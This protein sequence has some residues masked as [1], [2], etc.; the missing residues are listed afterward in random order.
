MPMPQTSSK[1]LIVVS[2]EGIAPTSM[3]CYGCSWN[4][5][6]SLDQISGHGLLWDRLFAN[7]D[8]PAEVL[9]K[10]TNHQSPWAA[11]YRSQ[12]P[13]ELFTDQA[14]SG[15]HQH[16]FDEINVLTFDPIAE[17]QIACD[18]IFDT[19]F[20]QLI[21]TAIQRLKQPADFGAIWIHSD[22]LNQC[23]DAPAD[24]DALS[25]ESVE[26]HPDQDDVFFGP[27]D[28]LNHDNTEIDPGEHHAPPET[29]SITPT[30][31][32]PPQIR[33]DGEADPD[34]LPQLM[35][36]Y[37]A[38]VQLIDQMLGYLIDEVERIGAQLVVVGTSG[39][40][41]GQDHEFGL[42]PT[43]LRSADLH[44][45]LIVAGC[46]PLRIPQLTSSDSVPQLLQLL[47][48]ENDF[49]YPEQQWASAESSVTPL[50]INSQRCRYA[51]IST[52]WFCTVDTDGSEY[53]F[54]KPDDLDDYNNVARLRTDIVDELVAIHQETE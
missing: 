6:P 18:D 42:R 14:T 2:L 23:W 29:A 15:S 24:N 27:V 43:R 5:T 32:L 11:S 3:S 26:D 50:T 19:R 44:L 7:D 36:R 22:F 31:V 28:D 4:H 35:D 34:M 20:G 39:F 12:G 38:Q 54:L 46:G 8:N 49:H 53:L 13:L 47:G 1:P 52:D 37:A 21:A 51:V 41:L 48:Q 45:P 25:T 17:D 33:I 10:W 40:R 9:Q 30:S 16:C